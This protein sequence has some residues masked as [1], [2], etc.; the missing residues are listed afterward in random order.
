MKG[1]QEHGLPLEYI[2]G[3][4]EPVLAVTDS[5]RKRD[6]SRYMEM[7]FWPLRRTSLRQANCAELLHLLRLSTCPAV[8]DLIREL[9]TSAKTV[10]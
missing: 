9:L 3:Y 1:A 7:K 2:H 10:K 5:N 8:V 4:I 6:Q